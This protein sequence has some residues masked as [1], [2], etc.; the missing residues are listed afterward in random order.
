MV[1]FIWLEEG[2]GSRPFDKAVPAC[3]IHPAE[4]S[5]LSSSPPPPVVA[6]ASLQGL[7]RVEDGDKDEYGNM[8]FEYSTWRSFVHAGRTPGR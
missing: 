1:R 4:T 2:V 8:R 3:T 5:T 6:A 7:P